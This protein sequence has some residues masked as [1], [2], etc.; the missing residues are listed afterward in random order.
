MNVADFL[1]LIEFLNRFS[2]R[3]QIHRLVIDSLS[4]IGLYY[5]SAV[6]FRQEFFLFCNFLRDKGLTAL[7]ITDRVDSSQLTRYGIEEYS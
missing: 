4:I 1:N 7:L 5:D 6:S 2:E 3:H